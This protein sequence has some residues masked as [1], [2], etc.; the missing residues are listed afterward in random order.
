MVIELSSHTD[1]QGNDNYNQRLSQRRA[2]SAVDWLIDNGIDPDRLRAVGY[3]ETQIL[4]RCRNGVKC[5]DD[6]HRF[7]RRTEFKIIEG[8]TS[9]EIKKEVLDEK[10]N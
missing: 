10:K 7:N 6:E 9:I 5:T 2:Q 3:G 4:N 1:A 8:P